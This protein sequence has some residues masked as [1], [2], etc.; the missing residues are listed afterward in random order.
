MSKVIASRKNVSIFDL[1][2]SCI[3]SERD[4]ISFRRSKIPEL[5]SWS[6]HPERLSLGVRLGDM[7]W[8]FDRRCL[9]DNDKVALS[10]RFR[11]G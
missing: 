9:S 11:C 5:H 3:E 1:D 10:F 8:S 6:F 4:L 2:P 7:K